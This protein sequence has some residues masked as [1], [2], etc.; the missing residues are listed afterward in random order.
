MNYSRF[1]EEIQ[2]SN[3][4]IIEWFKIQHFSVRICKYCLIKLP[5]AF[6][7]FRVKGSKPKICKI[8]CNNLATI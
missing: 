2:L 8:I 4:F 5:H 6:Q 7:L 3:L 1:I